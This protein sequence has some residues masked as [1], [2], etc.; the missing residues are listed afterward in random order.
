MNFGQNL[1][2]LRL[3]KKLTQEQVAQKL[4]VSTQTISRWECSSTYP[5]V[6]LL[7]ELSKLYG[8]TI[9]DLFKEDVISYENYAHRL[10]S[11]YEETQKLED[12]LSADNE[13]Q[14]LI[15]SGKYSSKDICMYGI[16]YQNL[17][18]FTRNKAEVI[19][20]QGLAE[21][22]DDDIETKQ[23]IKRQYML[24]LSQTGRNNENIETCL[25]EIKL[26]T[27]NQYAYI[28]IVFSYLLD[29]NPNEAIK[30]FKNGVGKFSDSYLLHF[31]G[32]NAYKDVNDFET[33]IKYYK[34]AWE[35]DQSFTMI[36]RALASCYEEVNDYENALKTWCE[37][38]KWLESHGYLIEA[39]L[40]D[41][42][43]KRCEK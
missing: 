36:L 9:D 4:N 31:Y 23:W 40:I 16:L 14:K 39:N 22:I 41:E 2:R 38:K 19:F 17:M 3:S 34:K 42:N 28:N 8:V 24:L 5:D 18:M 29:N 13:F 12:F 6:L 21:N 10:L 30:W 26:D 7:P 15:Q 32:A 27:N 20:K 11:V 43:I 1:K 37:V 33:A 35:L 25:N